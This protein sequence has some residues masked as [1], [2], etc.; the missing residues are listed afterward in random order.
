MELE[1]LDQIAINYVKTDFLFDFV[2]WIPY[3]L[4]L[5]YFNYNIIDSKYRLFRLRKLIRSK[6]A[7]NLI[8]LK[9]IKIIQIFGYFLPN[10]CISPDFKKD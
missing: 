7:I 6:K 5:F 3:E 10:S 1:T 8:S 4:F 9:F 2:A